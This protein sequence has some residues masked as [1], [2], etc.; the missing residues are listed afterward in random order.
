[1]PYGFYGVCTHYIGLT[2]FLI[3]TQMVNLFSL[4]ILDIIHMLVTLKVRSPN[5]SLQIIASYVLL[6]TMSLHFYV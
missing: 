1:M 5:I 6:S 4:I 3:Y 2:F